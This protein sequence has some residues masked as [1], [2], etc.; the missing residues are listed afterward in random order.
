M[1]N[2]SPVPPLTPD[3]FTGSQALGNFSRWL[4]TIVNYLNNMLVPVNQRAYDSTASLSAITIEAGILSTNIYSPAA[5]ITVTLSAP[6]GDGETRR[7]VFGAATT[8]TWA[9]IAPAT[10]AVIAKTI[11][12]AGESIELIYNAE[13]GSPANAPATSWIVF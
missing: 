7:I 8:V 13:S 4:A 2:I 12:S 9:V 5:K 10:A 3:V 11:F 6:S 1:N